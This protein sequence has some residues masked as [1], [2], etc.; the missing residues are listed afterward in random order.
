MDSYNV[1]ISPEAMEQLREHISYIRNVLF[2]PQAAE[3]VY[4]DAVETGE[5]LSTIAD[6]LKPCEDE[7]LRRYDYRKISFRRHKY[8]MIYRIEGRT[9]Y[10]DGIFHQKQDYENI[11]SNTQNL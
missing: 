6:V 10:V 1:I 9:V 2:N 5:K 11:F 4:D 7:R 8:V 3:S